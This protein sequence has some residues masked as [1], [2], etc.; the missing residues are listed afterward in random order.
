MLKGAVEIDQEIKLLLT[1]KTAV[2]NKQTPNDL[3]KIHHQFHG[4]GYAK[5]TTELV[6]FIDDFA[7]QTGILLDPIYTAKM[8]QGVI[9]LTKENYFNKGDSILTIHTGGLLGLLSSYT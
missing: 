9:T 5:T 1:Q 8:M 6:A 4:G 7:S 3:W 2:S